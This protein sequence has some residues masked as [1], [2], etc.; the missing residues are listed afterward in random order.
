MEG[1]STPID[2]CFSGADFAWLTKYQP[3]YMW[4]IFIF[5]FLEN[6]FVILVFLLHK[7]R[8]TIAEIY[9][10]NMAAADLVFVSSLPFFAISVSRGFNWPF[11]HFLCVAV[12]SLTILNLFSSIYFLMMVSIDRYLVLVKT[13]SVGRMRTTRWAKIVCILIWIFAGVVSIPKVIFRKAEFHKWFNTTVCYVDA[14]PNLDI[15]NNF[16]LNIVCF[17]IPVVVIGFCT[18]HIIKTLRNNTMQN[19]KEIKTEK[20][21]TWLVL[22]VLLVF[23]AC[24]LP[25]QISTFIDTLN[26]YR[27]FPPCSVDVPNEVFNQIS[28]YIGFSNSCLNPLLYVIVGNQFRK[29]AKAVYLQL[30]GRYRGR[31]P[32]MQMDSSLNTTQTSLYLDGQKKKKS[33]S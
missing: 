26:R 10:G 6:L 4:F 5:G 23:I 12:S 9:L 24:W 3:A 22:S 20:K 25:F 8:C 21:A 18:F 11:G 17:L 1:N 33:V 29:K 14:P 7:K 32:S 15:A 2:S 19:F 13:M 27:L 30:L 31:G 28:T 16:I